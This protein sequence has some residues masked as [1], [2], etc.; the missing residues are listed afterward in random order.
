MYNGFIFI[1]SLLWATETFSLSFNSFV[2]GSIR[3]Y[4]DLFIYLFIYLEENHQDP[5]INNVCENGATC[6]AIDKTDYKCICPEGFEGKY[7]QGKHEL[8]NL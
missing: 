6:V 4:F 5:C 8:G 7:C 1:C 3:E 2:N